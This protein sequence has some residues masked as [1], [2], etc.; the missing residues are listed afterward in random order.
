M[1]TKSE[2]TATR[3]HWIVQAVRSYLPLGEG[4]PGSG[5]D[6]MATE[7]ARAEEAAKKLNM[8]AG[9]AAQLQRI[10]PS[11]WL[12]WQNGSTAVCGQR[13]AC[14]S[15]PA[16]AVDAVRI[17]PRIHQPLQGSI[18]FD[19]VDGACRTLFHPKYGSLRPPTCQWTIMRQGSSHGNRTVRGACDEA[20]PRKGDHLLEGSVPAGAGNCRRSQKGI[21]IL[22]ARRGFG[23]GL[24]L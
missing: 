8:T 3:S 21:G 5:G 11:A 4:V 15:L 17:P 9:H 19:R 23:D 20:S 7:L 12:R 18:G 10:S 16:P 22:A 1:A 6:P 24:T 14:T 2:G 13:Q